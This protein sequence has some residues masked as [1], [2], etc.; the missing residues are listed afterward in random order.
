MRRKLKRVKLSAET[1]ATGIAYI[2]N[3]SQSMTC[4]VGYFI[5]LSKKVKLFLYRAM[6][7]H[8]VRD[9]E[10]PPFSRQSAHRWR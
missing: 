8:S 10:A 2:S 5:K 3:H 4:F 6:E 9:A 1:T 7:A